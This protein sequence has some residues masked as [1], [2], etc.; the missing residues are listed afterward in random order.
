MSGYYTMHR[1]WQDHPLFEGD[2]YSQRDAWEWLIA[3]ACYSER[4]ANISGRMIVLSR[5]E[6]S[7][8]VR[9]LAQKWRWKRSRV[10]RFLDRFKQEKMIKMR[11]RSVNEMCSK[12]GTEN[13]S[14]YG[15]GKSTAQQIITICNYSKY[16]K[17]KD[18][19]DSDDG[20]GKE[21]DS[22]TKVGQQRDRSGTKK[23][24]DNKEN[25]IMIDFEKFWA[26]YPRKVS[27]PSASKAFVLAIAKGASLEEIMKGLDTFINSKSIKENTDPAFIPHAATWLNNERWKDECLKSM[28]N[29]ISGL[30]Q[31]NLDGRW[32]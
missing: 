26:N 21:S 32:A 16:Q 29:S 18:D 17:T 5:G 30:L 20:T 19:Y 31:H 6:L 7:Y 2:E 27:K 10:S 25:T 28:S 24:K 3:N 11:E 23:N 4:E 15:T 9:F 13:E 22:G 12:I 8:S 1:G 14:N